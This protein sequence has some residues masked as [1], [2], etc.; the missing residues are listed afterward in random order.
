MEVDEGFLPYMHYI[1]FGKGINA[2]IPIGVGILFTVEQVYQLIYD[3]E[4]SP[5]CFC[6]FS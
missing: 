5:T 6:F 1:M 4:A 3:V 2:L